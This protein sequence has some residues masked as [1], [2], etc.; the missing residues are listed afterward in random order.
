[1]SSKHKF[2][3]KGSNQEDFIFSEENG[4][5]FEEAT[6]QQLKDLEGQKPILEVFSWNP[7]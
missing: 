2:K 5:P 7:T 1:M 6:P 4:E 3:V